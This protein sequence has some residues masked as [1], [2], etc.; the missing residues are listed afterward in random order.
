MVLRKDIHAEIG[1]GHIKPG[2]TICTGGIHAAD[3][4]TAQ[5]GLLLR[6]EYGIPLGAGGFR[7]NIGTELI[8]KI[9]IPEQGGIRTVVGQL[10][11]AH[12][13]PFPERAGPELAFTAEQ[14]F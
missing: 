12:I 9:G 8:V 10:T 4:R 3:K 14:Y 6:F 7:Q 2:R 1:L 13:F 11:K 5:H